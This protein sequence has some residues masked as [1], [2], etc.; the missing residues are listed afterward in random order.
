MVKDAGPDFL[1]ALLTLVL[2]AHDGQKA[3]FLKVGEMQS[4][5]T[6][7]IPKTGNLSI[8]STM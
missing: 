8:L 7:H 3:I 1:A 6:V 4:F 5:C 2:K